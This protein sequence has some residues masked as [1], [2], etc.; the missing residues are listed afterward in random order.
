MEE[1]NWEQRRFDIAKEVM[2]SRV[3][4]CQNVNFLNIDD[5]ADFSVKYADS[6]INR[7][8]QK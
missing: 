8:K 6:L 5:I 2:A 3:L 7:L 4:G 1:I